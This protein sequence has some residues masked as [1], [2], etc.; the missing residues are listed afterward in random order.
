MGGGGAG[1]KVPFLVRGDRDTA[2]PEDQGR[3]CYR[4]VGDG[5]VHGIMHGLAFAFVERGYC[6]MK[7]ILLV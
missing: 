4:I 3:K 2:D 6:E 7:D 1:G 5:Y